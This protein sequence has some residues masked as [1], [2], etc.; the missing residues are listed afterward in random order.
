[1]GYRVGR[2][3]LKGKQ[4]KENGKLV[5]LSEQKNKLSIDVNAVRLLNS[6]GDCL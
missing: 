4:K 3:K 5:L 1:M 6:R 2:I